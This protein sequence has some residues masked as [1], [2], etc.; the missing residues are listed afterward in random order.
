MNMPVVIYRSDNRAAAAMRIKDRLDNLN[1]C[2]PDAEVE[3]NPTRT[4][5]TVYYG[6]SQ[7]RH[8]NTEEY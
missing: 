1:A 3:T 2:R 7:A 8:G 4:I 5:T 6:A